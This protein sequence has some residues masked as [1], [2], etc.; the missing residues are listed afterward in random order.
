[1][2]YE[3]LSQILERGG[4]EAVQAALEDFAGRASEDKLNAAVDLA[5]KVIADDTARI[6]ARGD[7][8]KA[9]TDG[10]AAQVAELE[11]QAAEL[12]WQLNMQLGFA[13]GELLDPPPG[14]R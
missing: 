13:L 3:F 7:R 4:A 11:Q 5:C 12:E 6:R 2:D 14:G 10:L 9:E 8:H 1:M